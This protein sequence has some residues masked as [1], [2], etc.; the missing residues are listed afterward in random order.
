MRC[1]TVVVAVPVG[2]AVVAGTGA[3]DTAVGAEADIA[4]VVAV[5]PDSLDPR[6]A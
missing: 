3:V 4:L 2:T 6:L 5:E 1:R